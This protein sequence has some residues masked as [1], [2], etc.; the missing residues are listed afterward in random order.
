MDS[1]R[2]FMRE[3][4]VFE[5]KPLFDYFT[6][7]RELTRFRRVY[8][9]REMAFPYKADHVMYSEVTF[10]WFYLLSLTRECHK[11]KLSISLVCLF[12]SCNLPI[13]PKLYL[14]KHS[15]TPAFP[16]SINQHCRLRLI[17][18]SPCIR[19]TVVRHRSTTF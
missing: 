14:N 13:T 16:Q 17:S 12:A 15:E 10:V 4:K 2:S 9:I 3:L 19:G 8:S 11:M 7:L 6:H 5:L 18:L 1:I